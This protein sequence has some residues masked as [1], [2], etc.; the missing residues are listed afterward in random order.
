MGRPDRGWAGALLTWTWHGNELQAEVSRCRYFCR[1]HGREVL[2][3]CELRDVSGGRRCEIGSFG[4]VAAAKAACERHAAARCRREVD[5]CPP[6]DVR[7]APG[8][9]RRVGFNSALKPVRAR[10]PVPAAA[11]DID[12]ALAAWADVIADER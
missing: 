2:A 8:R 6:V 12:A 1:A 7:I 10:E 11:G 5:M 9:R 4:D 3:W